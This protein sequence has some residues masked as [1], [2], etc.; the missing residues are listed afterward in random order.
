MYIHTLATDGTQ[1]IAITEAASSGGQFGHPVMLSAIRF[2]LAS[3]DQAIE[4]LNA[5][6]HRYA[7]SFEVI[8][9]WR[10]DAR[11][12]GPRSRFGKTLAA[13]RDEVG[14]NLSGKVLCCATDDDAEDVVESFKPM[15]RAIGL[16]LA[17]P[18]AAQSTQRERF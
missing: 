7:K 17:L 16:H 4:E 10:V 12:Q 3:F 11:N 18:A 8:E 1:V 6:G 13:L 14:D 9:R 5:K 2:D 15:A